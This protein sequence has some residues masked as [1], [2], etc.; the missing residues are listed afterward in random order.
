MGSVVLGKERVH[1]TQKNLSVI[2]GIVETHTNKGDLVL[3]PF[4]GSGT[5]ARACQ[6]LGRQFIGSEINPDYHR[7]AKE[8]INN[9]LFMNNKRLKL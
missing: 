7:K 1:P 9:F 2:K 4:M 5:L 3:D 8:R 6:E